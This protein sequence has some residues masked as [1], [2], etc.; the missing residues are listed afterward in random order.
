MQNSA[1]RP[2]LIFIKNNGGIYINLHTHVTHIQTCVC[3]YMHRLYHSS[4]G[5]RFVWLERTFYCIF[6]LHFVNVTL[7][8][9]KNNAQVPGRDH[10]MGACR[11]E[12]ELRNF[13][14]SQSGG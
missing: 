14:L 3:L 12:E 8:E 9:N 4:P 10:V 11:R 6:F 13:I 2:E 7:C 5:V 1:C